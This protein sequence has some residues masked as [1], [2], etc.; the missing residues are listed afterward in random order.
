MNRQSSRHIVVIITM[1]PQPNRIN[2][3]IRIY[4]K[5]K[6]HEY[7]IFMYQHVTTLYKSFEQWLV[8]YIKHKNVS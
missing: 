4:L 8:V 6:H 5:V 2:S 1:A 7:L 3:L